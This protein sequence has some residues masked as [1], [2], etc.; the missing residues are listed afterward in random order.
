L[1]AQFQPRACK[2]NDLAKIRHRPVFN[3]SG[4]RS[5]ANTCET[6]PG[7][8]PWDLLL[9]TSGDLYRQPLDSFKS[10]KQAS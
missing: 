8:S 4:R 3:T 5:L 9:C 2:L 1:H 10:S 7:D 6:K